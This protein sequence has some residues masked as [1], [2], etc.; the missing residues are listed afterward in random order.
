MF[1]GHPR[2]TSDPAILAGKPVIRGMRIRVADVLGYLAGGET[3]QSLLEEFEELEDED[4]T[5]ALR[6][7]ADIIS[8]N[9]ATLIAA[10]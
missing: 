10:E 6:F 3:R 9:P 8:K 7:A 1:E 2:I 5:A 4:I